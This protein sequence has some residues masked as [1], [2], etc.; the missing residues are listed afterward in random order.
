MQYYALITSF[1]L[2]VCFTALKHSEQ[3]V[4]STTNMTYWIHKFF[5]NSN[6]HWAQFG[7]LNWGYTWLTFSKHLQELDVQGKYEIL[8]LTKSHK[9]R[10]TCSR[11]SSLPTN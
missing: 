2:V 4:V 6:K 8:I 10:H 11:I 5:L 7:S 9:R 3:G 1:E